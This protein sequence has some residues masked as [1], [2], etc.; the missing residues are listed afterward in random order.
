MKIPFLSAESREDRQSQRETIRE[1]S[2][3]NRELFDAGRDSRQRTQ[4][5]ADERRD[6]SACMLLHR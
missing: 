5:I 4:D 1:I 3:V 2:R 6:E